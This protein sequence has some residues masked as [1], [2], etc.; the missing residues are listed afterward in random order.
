ME[1]IFKNDAKTIVDTLFENQLLRKSFKRSDMD[2]LEGLIAYMMN[3]RF[4]SYKKM[5]ELSDKVLRQEMD[6]QKGNSA[7][8]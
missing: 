3:S 7:A 4:D 8:T 1:K 2:H 6:S 5:T